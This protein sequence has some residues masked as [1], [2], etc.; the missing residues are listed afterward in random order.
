M[1]SD[2]YK[3]NYTSSGDLRLELEVLED[4]LLAERCLLQKGLDGVHFLIADED[5]ALAGFIKKSLT[6]KFKKAI[7]VYAKNY[8][9]VQKLLNQLEPD[10]L[11][12]GQ[13]TPGKEGLS[14]IE[15]LQ[16][17]ADHNKIKILMMTDSPE[18]RSKSDTDELPEVQGV[19]VKPFTSSQLIEVIKD[20][21]S[22]AKSTE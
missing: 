19:L 1:Q 11:I 6:T 12:T 2:S 22:G 21:L 18:T 14:L 9:Q 4:I 3:Q 8:R 20:I 15:T 5:L 13:Y 16:S 17:S 10:V 7:I